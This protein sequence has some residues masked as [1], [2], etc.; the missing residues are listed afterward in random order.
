MFQLGPF[1]RII[2]EAYVTTTITNLDLHNIYVPYCYG[3]LYSQFKKCVPI[4]T[5]YL[6][7]KQNGEEMDVRYTNRHQALQ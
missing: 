4:S 5:D 3:L 2:I 1:R 7:P 6:H